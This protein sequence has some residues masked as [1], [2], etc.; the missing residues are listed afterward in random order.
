[1]SVCLKGLSSSGKSFIVK[2]V[3]EH[4]PDDAYFAASA[5][6]AKALFYGEGD[7]RHKML[8]LNEWRGVSKEGGY[9][10]ETLLSEGK[11]QYTT[12]V[13]TQNEG[14]KERRI[15]REGPTGFI[16]TTTRTHIAG[17]MEN[18]LFAVT[19]ADTPEQTKRVFIEQSIDRPARTD[20]EWVL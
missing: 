20:A 11:L 16:T 1:M 4:F 17:D 9:P 6:S 5:Y 12:V 2:N 19:I 3:L 15:E 13:P 10:M 18:R 8:V 14:P 7:L